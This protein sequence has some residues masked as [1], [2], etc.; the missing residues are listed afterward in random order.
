MQR[1][2]E[3]GRVAYV[4]Y[5]PYKGKLV[6]IVDILNTTRVL[7]HGPKDG[8]RRQEISVKRITPTDFKL[9]IHNGIHKDAL[10]KAIDDFKLED[11]VK[12]T[13]F[14]KKIERRAKRAA[15]TDFDRYKVMLLR[16]KRATLR[17]KALAK[18][19]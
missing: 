8:V 16:Q 12:E 19:K 15:L 9:D 10:I 14:A 2:V 18:K 5:G 4:N 11:K 7:I 6:V 13:P 3:V 17:N 1:F